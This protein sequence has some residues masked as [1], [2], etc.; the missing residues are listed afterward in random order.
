MT[1]R[2]L[3]KEMSGGAL[4]DRGGARAKKSR[5]ARVLGAVVACVG[6]AC[7][8]APATCANG[9]FYL[10]D[11]DRVVFYGDSITQQGFYS[12]YIEDFVVTR[13]PQWNV[14]FVNSGW[15]GDWAVGGGGGKAELR[16]RRDVLAHAPTV[17]TVL[18]GT[19]DAAYQKFDQSFF[20]VYTDAYRKL[21]AQIQSAPAPPRMTLLAPTAFDDVTR[22]PQFEGGYNAV[23]AVMAS[24]CCSS[25]RKTIL[26]AST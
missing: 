11:G 10:R 2:R 20:D 9:D 21:L 19:N 5:I 6:M 15:S 24:S 14:T 17:V 13:F 25:R 26:P 12:S 22:P 23:L 4:T 7:S 8:A 1:W 18:L 3:A 16:L